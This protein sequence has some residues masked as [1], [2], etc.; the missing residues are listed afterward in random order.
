MKFLWKKWL[1][2]IIKRSIQAAIAVIGAD[3]LA[4]WGVTLDPT[5]LTVAVFALI[6][7]LRNLLKH[8]VGVKFL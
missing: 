4:S 1:T 3:K 2:S 7:A 8:K 5:A 6:E